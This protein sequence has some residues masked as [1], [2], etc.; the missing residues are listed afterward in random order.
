MKGISCA[1]CGSEDRAKAG[2]KYGKQCHKCKGCA[3][4]L[5]NALPLLKDI[6]YSNFP[7]PE[8]TDKQKAETERLGGSEMGG[9][10]VLYRNSADQWKNRSKPP[11]RLASAA[12][13][14]AALG[15]LPPDLRL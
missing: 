15:S 3:R 12:A 1:P 8:A 11:K 13:L 6:V 7:W 14:L 2:F 10:D 9:V 5:R 4:S